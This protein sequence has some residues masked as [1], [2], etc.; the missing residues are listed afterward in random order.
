MVVGILHV[1]LHLP[2]SHS[3]KERRQVVGGLGRRLSRTFG[4]SAAE[5]GGQDLWQVAE[6][7]VAFVG[8]AGRDT[9]RV[10]Q[11]V[12]NYLQDRVE[13]AVVTSVIRETVR[14]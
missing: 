10:L 2:G 8:N 6:L 9:E 7:G 1:T 5:V 4:V 12:T 3:L 13:D 11:A 14:L